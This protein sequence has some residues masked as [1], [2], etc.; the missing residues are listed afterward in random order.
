MIF[1]KIFM[2]LRYL[3]LHLRYLSLFHKLSRL[4]SFSFA[5]P[6]CFIFL[7]GSYSSLSLRSTDSRHC[8]AFMSCVCI[9]FITGFISI[10]FLFPTRS[11][12]KSSCWSS[13]KLADLAFFELS[14]IFWSLLL[15]KINLS[16]CS[17][18]SFHLLEKIFQYF[19]RLSP[20][21]LWSCYLG[22]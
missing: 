7:T 11:P 4:W 8:E 3:H 19:F 18:I 21:I 9:F 22:K 15:Y 17:L 2:S 5:E 6:A 13:P 20:V 12:R 16:G 10:L 1:L 14:C